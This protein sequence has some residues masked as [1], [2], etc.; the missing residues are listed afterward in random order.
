MFEKQWLALALIIFCFWAGGKV[1]QVTG[2]LFEATFHLSF[3]DTDEL[4]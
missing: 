4:L 1:S 2:M 3:N